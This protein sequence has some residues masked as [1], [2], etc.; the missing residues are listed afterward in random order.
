MNTQIYRKAKKRNV[1]KIIRLSGLGISLS[2]LLMGLYIFFPLLSWEVY[3]KPAFAS[4]TFASPIP[5]TT[6][7]TKDY[8]KSL[9]KNTENTFKGL[10]YNNAQNWLPTTTVKSAEVTSGTSAYY[11][12][13]PS[14]NI[15]NATVSTIDVDLSQHLVHF[16]G[17]TVPPN[18]GTA[19]VFG[20]STL[21]QLYDRSN[22]K[23]IFAYAHTLQVGDMI[24]VSVNNQSY[25]YKIIT[26]SIVDPE[27]TDTFLSQQYDD[28]YLNIITCTPPGTTWKRLVI[29]S[30]L[31]KT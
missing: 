8:I 7:I 31:Q 23:T 1:R 24:N 30:R 4:T 16:P 29:K 6:I 3:L 19:A 17:T 27:D 20:H 11:I 9:I 15:Q 12:S 13:I 14:I 5:Q 10:D 21:P 2:S 22:Y 25:N 26:I 18:K 28:S